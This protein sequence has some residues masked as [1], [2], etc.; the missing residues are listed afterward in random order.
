MKSVFLVNALPMELSTWKTHVLIRKHL[1]QQECWNSQYVDARSTETQSTRG[2][3]IQNWMEGKKRRRNCH[4]LME[5]KT[6]KA[7]ELSA[8]AN[9]HCGKERRVAC[10]A[11]MSNTCKRCSLPQSCSICKQKREANSFLVR[12]LILT[13][14]NPRNDALLVTLAQH[15][16]R[17]MTPPASCW[18]AAKANRALQKK[19]FGADAT[20]AEKRKERPA[21]RG[22]RPDAKDALF[23]SLAV[24]VSSL[25][26]QTTS[27]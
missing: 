19:D 25:G 7:V 17:R 16:A 6:K 15:A 1:K 8:S 10:F 18:V 24:S 2:G 23:R 27:L 26:K 22:C 21:S 13:S 3:L 4:N 12:T 9:K 20:D 14:K 11:K 5:G